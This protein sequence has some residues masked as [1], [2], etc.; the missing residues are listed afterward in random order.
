MQIHI[1]SIDL[2]DLLK[3]KIG[4]KEAKTLVIYIETKAEEVI[5]EKKDIFLTK[6]DKVDIMKSIYFVGLVQFLAIVTSVI[7]IVGFML[8]H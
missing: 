7:A 1:T 3:P 5:N 8:R 6:D 2:F 4:E